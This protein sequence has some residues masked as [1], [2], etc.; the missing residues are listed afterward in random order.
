MNPTEMR[1]LIPARGLAEYWYPA[2][3]ERAVGRRRGACC[4]SMKPKGNVADDRLAI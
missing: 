4:E 3:R 2:L 1:S